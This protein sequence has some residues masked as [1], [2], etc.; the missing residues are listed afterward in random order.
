MVSIRNYVVDTILENI[1]KSIMENPMLNVPSVVSQSFFKVRKGKRVYQTKGKKVVLLSEGEEFQ[2]SAKEI[3]LFYY[4][5]FLY[6]EELF[7]QH[8]NLLIKE[9]VKHSSPKG[10]VKYRHRRNETIKIKPVKINMIEF[11]EYGLVGRNSYDPIRTFIKKLSKLS[12]ITNILNKDRKTGYEEEI[13]VIDTHSW[14]T[15]KSTLTISLSESL[16]DLIIHREDLFMKVDLNNLKTLSGVKAKLLYL[17]LKDYSGNGELRRKD[18][19]QHDLKQLI[20]EIPKKGVFDGIIKQI[21][22]KTDITVTCCD[23]VGFKDKK[24][25]KFTLKN[26]AEIESTEPEEEVNKEVMEIAEQQL[27]HQKERNKKTGMKIRNEAGYLRKCYKTEME[28]FEDKVTIDDWLDEQKEGLGYDDTTT[29]LPFIVIDGGDFFPINKGAGEMRVPI[30]IDDE[31]RL[32][33]LFTKKP[34]TNTAAET[35]TELQK[36]LDSGVEAFV[37][38]YGGCS[39]GNTKSCFFS[40]EELERKGAI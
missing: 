6:R 14:G 3:N 27:E 33:R 22:E 9:E 31:Y 38:Y 20:G 1:M 18:L 11:A 37:D 28:I 2:L 39:V 16:A 26:N 34:L 24:E 32:T 19:K 10:K 4:L 5:L 40:T 12:I 25:Y 30:K 36:I 15:T 23:P 29:E 13:K 7:D 17:M 21:N 8:K 35:I